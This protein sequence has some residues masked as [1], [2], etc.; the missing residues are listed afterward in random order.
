MIVREAVEH[1]HKKSKN[2][3]QGQRGGNQEICGE[4]YVSV[5]QV[6]DSGSVHVHAS[7]FTRRARSRS[8]FVTRLS[9]SCVVS[10]RRTVL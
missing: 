9:A 6:H 5:G 1:D 4:I 3:Q 2:R 7:I 10:R 8:K